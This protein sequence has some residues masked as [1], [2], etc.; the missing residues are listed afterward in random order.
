[1]SEGTAISM[2]FKA[3]YR[4]PPPLFSVLKDFFDVASRRE[5]LRFELRLRDC[6][7]VVRVYDEGGRLE[8]L[9]ELFVEEDERGECRATGAAV[10]TSRPAPS[11]R[12]AELLRELCG[13]LRDVPAAEVRE[14]RGV[15][16]REV[17]GRAR[18]ATGFSSCSDKIFADRRARA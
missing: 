17:R 4:R 1:V 3:V 12:A 7:V 13:R 5:G 6:A 8:A 16:D 10:W 2:A 18:E 14:V 15:G 9:V 11:P